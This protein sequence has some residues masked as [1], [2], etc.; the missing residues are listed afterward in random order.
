MLNLFK[1]TLYNYIISFWLEMNISIYFWYNITSLK[2]LI[3]MDI[4]YVGF[5]KTM[6]RMPV[7]LSASVFPVIECH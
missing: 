4:I 1:H 2:Q 6:Q 5:M 7:N 3:G